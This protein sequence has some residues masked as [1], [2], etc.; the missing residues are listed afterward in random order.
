VTCKFVLGRLSLV[1]FVLYAFGWYI[2]SYSAPIH[3]KNL[4]FVFLTFLKVLSG[5]RFALFWFFSETLLFGFL[6]GW[7]LQ[8]PQIKTLKNDAIIMTSSAFFEFR[9][10]IVHYEKIVVR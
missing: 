6:E 4:S 3:P 1:S 8:R 9:Q 10:W 7:L 2:G 5:I